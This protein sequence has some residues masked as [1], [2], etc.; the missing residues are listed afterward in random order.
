[1]GAEQGSQQSLIPSC[2]AVYFFGDLNRQG[3]LSK[4][5]VL[6]SRVVSFP[7]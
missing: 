5:V 4:V 7:S 6:S 1:M 3:A 2:I